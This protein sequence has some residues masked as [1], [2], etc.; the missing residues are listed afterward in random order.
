[1]SALM[2]AYEESQLLQSDE[3]RKKRFARLAALAGRLRG[4]PIPTLEETHTHA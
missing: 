1:V 3:P 4:R 2:K